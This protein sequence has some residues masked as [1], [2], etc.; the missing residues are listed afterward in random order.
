MRYGGKLFIGRRGYSPYAKYASNG[1]DTIHFVGT[2]DH[3]RNFDNSLYHGFIRAGTIHQS[4]GTPV[5]PLATSSNTTVHVWD[6]TRVYQG[7]PSNVAWMTDLHLDAQERPV[8][9]FSV[10]RDGAG[11]P[12]GQGGMDHRFHLGRWDGSRWDVHEIADRF[13]VIDRGEIVASIEKGKTSLKQ[14]DEFLLEY[15]HG[16][17]D[18]A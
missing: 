1:R 9:L 3:P 5:A 18:Q 7:G 14:L 8:V 10:Q 12:K 17:K 15:S 2:E 11:L 16:L 13:V 4:D 6:L